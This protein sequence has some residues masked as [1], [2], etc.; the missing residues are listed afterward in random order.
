MDTPELQVLSKI[1]FFATLAFKSE[2]LPER[3][4]FR[5]S[6]HCCENFVRSSI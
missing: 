3:S 5:F 6:S 2:P 1:A 4:G